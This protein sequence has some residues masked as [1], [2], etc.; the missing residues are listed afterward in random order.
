MKSKLEAGSWKLGVCPM[1]RPELFDAGL[2]RVPRVNPCHHHSRAMLARIFAAVGVEL[3]R[4][5]SECAQVISKEVPGTWPGPITLPGDVS[6][7]VQRNQGLAESSIGRRTD[8]TGFRRVC[9][10]CEAVMAPSASEGPV[11]HGICPRCLAAELN[12]FLAGSPAGAPKNEA[13]YKKQASKSKE[14]FCQ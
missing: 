9:A 5:E 14:V 11:S 4:H 12:G 10:W 2:V 3:K 8:A 13:S 6:F 1:C 7:F